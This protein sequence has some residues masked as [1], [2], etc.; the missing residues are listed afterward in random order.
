MTDKKVNVEC[1]KWLNDKCV[2][3]SELESG[4]IVADVRKCVLPN[5]LK[6]QEFATKISHSGFRLEVGKAPSNSD[7]GVFKAKQVREVSK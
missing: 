5:Q 2:E 6:A 4:K 1:V 3:W 7:T